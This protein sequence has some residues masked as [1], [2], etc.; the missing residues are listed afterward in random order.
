L[1][2][3]VPSVAIHPYVGVRYVDLDNDIVTNYFGLGGFPDG[4]SNAKVSQRTQFKGGVIDLLSFL[5][6]LGRT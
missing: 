3:P 5:I 4:T 6:L 1:F 2:E